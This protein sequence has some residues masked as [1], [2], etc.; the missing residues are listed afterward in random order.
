[1]FTIFV[2][3]LAGC[4]T[5]DTWKPI[6]IRNECPHTECLKRGPKYEGNA[7]DP[8]NAHY[9]IAC[10]K[11]LRVGCLDCPN[12]LIFVEGHDACM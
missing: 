8:S 7:A 11:G 2:D 1:M 5:T 10:W 12:D 3:F 6:R 9:Y 4:Y